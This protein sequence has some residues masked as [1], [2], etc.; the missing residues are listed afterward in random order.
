MKAYNRIRIYFISGGNCLDL[1]TILNKVKDHNLSLHRANKMKKYAVLLP[2]I[3][4]NQ[5][6]HL[7]FEVRSMNLRS[8]P[9]DVCFPGGRVEPTDHNEKFGAMRETSEELGISMKSIH[10]VY[11]LDVMNPSPGQKIYTFVG[12]L[13]SQIPL[14]PN[15]KEVAEVFSVPLNYLLNT[16]P[17]KYEVTIEAMPE[18]DFPFHLI[19]GGKNYDWQVRTVNQYFYTFKDYVIWGLTANIILNFLSLLQKE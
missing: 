14:R 2:L 13:D 9:G 7:L 15:K 11:P 12:R 4:K 5:E 3:E 6:T 17:K 1:T 8:Q 10:D 18:E 16:K 19:V